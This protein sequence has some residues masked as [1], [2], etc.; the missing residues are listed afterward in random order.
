M[1]SPRKPEA[2]SQKPEWKRNY[3]GFWLLASGFL[4]LHLL[5]SG[6]MGALTRN[7]RVN[8]ATRSATAPLPFSDYMRTI[9]RISEEGAQESE[10]QRQKLLQSHPELSELA[11][12]VAADAANT[13]CRIK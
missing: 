11:A 1:G 5:L 4:L 8:P 6:C 10:E 7:H 2:R 13:D 3:S 9:Y 12:C